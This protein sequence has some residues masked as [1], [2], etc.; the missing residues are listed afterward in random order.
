ME[1]HISVPMSI[2]DALYAKGYLAYNKEWG[3]YYSTVKLNV[4]N[5]EFLQNLANLG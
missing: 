3:Y 1:V 5:A 2:V 4:P